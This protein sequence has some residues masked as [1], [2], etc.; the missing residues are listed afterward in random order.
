MLRNIIYIISSILLFFVGL[1][2][3][4]ILLNM[5]EI[6]LEEAM[7]QKNLETIKNPSIFVDRRNYFLAL[8]ADTVLVKKYDAVFGRNSGSNKL[9]KDDFI[10]PTG[11]Y[12][13]CKIDTNFIYYKKLYLNYPNINDAAE[14]LRMSVIDKN[15]FIAISNSNNNN[16]CSFENSKLGGNIGIQGIGEYNIIF[17]NLPF[18]FNWTNGSIAVSNENIDELLSVI[19]IGTKV[20]I[21]N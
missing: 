1:I 5:R 11:K 6:S 2:L 17:K 7:I 16:G 10:T 13:I 18:V 9:S 20:T 8:Y 15:E 14:A 3:Y 21:K 19:T 12:R 4:G